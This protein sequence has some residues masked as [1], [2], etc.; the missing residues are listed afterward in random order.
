MQALTNA[1]VDKRDTHGRDRAPSR[2]LCSSVMPQLAILRPSWMMPL[3]A[4]LTLPPNLL[5]AMLLS[6]LASSSERHTWMVWVLR[7]EWSSL[8]LRAMIRCVLYCHYF[9]AIKLTSFRERIRLATCPALSRLLSGERLTAT[10]DS[11]PA[12]CCRTLV[13]NPWQQG[14]Q[15]VS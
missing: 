6:L 9:T 5:R 8:F 4:T 11:M 1:A 13:C 12:S 15:G 3:A 10:S 14:L 2:Y 7:G